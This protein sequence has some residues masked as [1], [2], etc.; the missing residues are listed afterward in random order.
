MRGGHGLRREGGSERAEKNAN[1]ADGAR[2]KEGEEEGE[3]ETAGR[4][5]RL[6]KSMA[7]D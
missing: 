4:M 7:G 3:G 5:L 1:A 6:R 2:L